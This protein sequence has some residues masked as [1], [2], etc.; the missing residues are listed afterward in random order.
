MLESVMGIIAKE[1]MPGFFGALAVQGVSVLADPLHIMYS[2]LNKFLNRSPSWNIRK[3]PLYWINKI[4]LQPPD[5]D[6]TY[7]QEMEW[8]LDLFIDGLRS[9]AVGS[10]FLARTE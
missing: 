6:D 3:L 9:V 5:A 8:L 1:P 4:L 10:D 2:K 7:V